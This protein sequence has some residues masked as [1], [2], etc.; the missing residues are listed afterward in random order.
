LGDSEGF[1]GKYDFSKIKTTIP[2]A[3]LMIFKSFG[4]VFEILLTSSISE[5]G[6][7]KKP[8]CKV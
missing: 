8:R 5:T 6:S 1:Q 2:N 3:F 7:S 4:E